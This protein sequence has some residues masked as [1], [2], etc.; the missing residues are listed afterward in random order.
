MTTTITDQ[1]I[2]GAKIKGYVGDNYKEDNVF[3][4]IFVAQIDKGNVTI[5]DKFPGPYNPSINGT[6]TLLESNINILE[7]DIQEL[8]KTNAK[9]NEK[10]ETVDKELEFNKQLKKLKEQD[11][12]NKLKNKG[13]QKNSTELQEYTREIIKLNL[14]IKKYEKTKKQYEDS[15][16]TNNYKKIKN[17]NKINDYKDSLNKLQSSI[18]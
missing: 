17:N 13:E 11:N 10:L 5:V 9:F 18:N 3:T 4:G 7:E 1:L 8:D 6:V 15:I 12:D 2:K 14:E 16:Q